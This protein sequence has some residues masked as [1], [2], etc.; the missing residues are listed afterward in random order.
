MI[1]AAL[2]SAG[3]SAG[4]VAVAMEPDMFG[5]RGFPGYALSGGTAEMA[6]IKKRIAELEARVAVPDTEFT[7]G[8]VKVVLAENRVQIHFP[9]K[10]ISHSGRDR[11]TARA[12]QGRVH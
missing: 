9:G 10:P 7:F 8:D 12:A 3:I 11:R 5:K 2:L 6:R 4:D 1:R